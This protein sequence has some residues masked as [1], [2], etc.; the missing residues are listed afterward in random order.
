MIWLSGCRSRSPQVYVVLV[1]QQS[2]WPVD[3]ALAARTTGHLYIYI[4][5]TW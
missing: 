2:T 4:S 3:A 1:D 5:W